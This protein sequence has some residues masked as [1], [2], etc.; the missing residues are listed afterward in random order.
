MAD[1]TDDWLYDDD[2]DAWLAEWEEADRQAAEVLREACPVEL[3][4]PVPTQA[5]GRAA[6]A[7]RDGLARGRWPYDYFVN[8]CGWE[9][10]APDD[11]V[12][13]WLSALASSMSP[14][15]DPGIDVEEASAVGALVHA[16]WL[17]MVVGL[18][19]RGA[20]A[21]FSAEAAQRDIDT[22]PEL[23]GEIEDPDGAFGVLSMAVTTLTPLWQAL[24]VLDDDESLTELGRWGL[25]HA[26]LVTWSVPDD[27]ESEAGSGLPGG[28]SPRLAEEDAETVLAILARRPTTFEELRREAA[29]EGVFASV[30]QLSASL[31]WRLEVYQFDD[32]VLAHLPTLADGLLL[33]HRVTAAELELGVLAADLDLDL[34]GLLTL[35]GHPFAGG[36]ELKSHFHDDDLP[37][38]DGARTGVA[39]PGGWLDGFTP[40]DLLGIR[41]VDGQLAVERVDLPPPEQTRA[42][43]EV[44]LEYARNAA[45]HDAAHG[46]PNL[47]GATANEIVLRSRLEHP[48]LF[49]T[50]LPPLSEILAGADGL[51]VENGFVGLPGTAWHGEPSWLGDRERST[52]RTWRR[53]LS[54]HRRDGSLPEPAELAEL[55]EALDGRLLPLAATSMTAEPD[56]EPVAAAMAEAVSGRLSAVPAYLRAMAAE[57]RGDVEAWV[58]HLEAAVAADE[59]CEEAVAD[60]ADLRAVAGDAREAHRLYGLAGLETTAPEMQVLT[61]F[62][63]PPEGVGRNKPCPCGSGKKYKVCHGRTDAH[64]LP[65]R[66]AW[67][68]HK[69]NTFCQ[70]GANR[71]VLLDWAELLTGASRESQ[72]VVFSAM[73]DPTVVDFAAFGDGLLD[74]FLEVLG[75]LLPADERELA[76]GWIGSPLRLME[77]AQLRP[78]RGARVRDLV[79]GQD[80]EIVDRRMSTGVEVKDVLLGRPLDDGSDTLRLQ[81]SPLSIPRTMRGRLLALLREGGDEEAVAG[82]IADAASPPEM[83]TTEGEELVMC[84]AR[85]ELTSPD[86]TW[87]ALSAEMA[88]SDEDNRLLDET[89]VPGQGSVVRGS[90]RRD[91]SR[92]VVETNAVERL[93]RIQGRVLAADPDAR[94][95]DES[96]RPMASLLEEGLPD[97]GL[98]EDGA[99]PLGTP[100]PGDLDPALLREVVRRHEENWLDDHIPALQG[101]TPREA[102]QDPVL[103]EDLVALLDDFEWQDRR[104]PGPLAMDVGRLRRELGLGEG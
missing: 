20:G 62:L 16:D 29:K 46:D 48:G 93:R 87:A 28:G 103:R 26:L 75:P 66:A 13:L 8:A 49:A 95:V 39:G 80:L 100:D 10:D 2:E 96:T 55:A 79:T 90:V 53:V 40:G 61:R 70:R 84:T 89:D 41:Y 18:V 101:R 9:N 47:P 33:T 67:L 44:V 17:G 97:E 60:L 43:V 42:D 3:G 5:V 22:L 59:T 50:P 34:P 7:L 14:P 88:A 6:S 37:M 30:D 31:V 64:P 83:T 65:E 98:P 69:L 104:N 38:P 78:M 77:V 76:Q 68:W 56:R 32:G 27:A 51:E 11:D 1:D 94:L 15:N 58:A 102:A 4:T 52:Y 99:G 91:G 86:E 85:Y 25:P 45:E 21:E 36:G 82:F 23:E 12:E 71:P 92:L 73:G 72:E 63:Q 24:G 19:R 57:A 74:R 35:D 54:S 81:T